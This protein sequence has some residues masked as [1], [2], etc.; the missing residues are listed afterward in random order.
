MQC[1]GAT[2]L[3]TGVAN[4]RYGDA[5]CRKTAPR[6]PIRL[7]AMIENEITHFLADYAARLRLAETEMLVVVHLGHHR[8][9]IA[10]R[11][12]NQGGSDSIPFPIR[13]IVADALNLGTQE[14]ILAHNHPSGCARP[15]AADLDETRRLDKLLRALQIAVADHLI[16]AHDECYSMRNAG[17][18]D[19]VTCKG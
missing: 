14:L 7:S 5:C 1:N 15:S 10:R 6:A 19:V 11:I 4:V 12:S 3:Q 17:L 9:V 18:L 2:S 16:F 8:S 13:P